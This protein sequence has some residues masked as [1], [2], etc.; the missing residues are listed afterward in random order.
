VD[1]PALAYVGGNKKL[2]IFKYLCALLTFIHSR[3]TLHSSYMWKPGERIILW[4]MLV[5]KGLEIGGRESVSCCCV[6][7]P[8]C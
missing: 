3:A 5:R 1:V 4:R 6:W 8:P 2:R 7:H